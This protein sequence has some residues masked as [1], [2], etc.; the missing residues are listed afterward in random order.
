M[1]CFTPLLVFAGLYLFKI[2][3]FKTKNTG[4]R[5]TIF[6]S[7]VFTTMAFDSHFDAEFE[8]HVPLYLTAIPPSLILMAFSIDKS[9]EIH[10]EKDECRRIFNLYN[11]KFRMCITHFELIVT[12]VFCIMTTLNLTKLELKGTT[13]AEDTLIIDEALFT[14]LIYLILTMRATGQT[15]LYIVFYQF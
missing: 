11:S 15:V 6:L 13:K 5:I 8:K 9:V 12:L 3:M 2:V 14:C 1:H 4:T 10:F 7:L